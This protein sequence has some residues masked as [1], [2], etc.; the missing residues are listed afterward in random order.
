MSR[1]M[2]RA[3]FALCGLMLLASGPAAA[4]KLALV[5][6]NS[7]YAKVGTLANPVNDATAM[8]RALTGIG[9]KVTL[10]TDARKP[11]LEAALNGFGQVVTPADQVLVFYAGHGVQAAGRNYL[12]PVDARLEEERSLRLETVDLDVIMDQIER[13]A[14]RV[15]ILDA[16]R[17]NPFP[18]ASR[19]GS[20][21]LAA[22]TAPSGSL[23][24]YSTA[25]GQTASDGS[26]ANGLYTAALLKAVAKDVP[27]ESMFKEVRRTVAQASGGAQVPWE[28]SSLTG[29][30]VLAATAPVPA[31]A[32]GLPAPADGS[33][34]RVAAAV[35]P[36]PPAAAGTQPEA[37]GLE[38]HAMPAG[39]EP[40]PGP[41]G[42]P[43]RGAA[44]AGR[45]LDAVRAQANER[46]KARDFAGARRILEEARDSG[47]FPPPAAAFLELWIAKTFAGEGRRREALQ[48]LA[49][50]AQ[51]RPRAPA[52]V[53]A[54]L[55]SAH[56]FGML[57]QGADAC[58]ELA[59]FHRAFAAASRMPLEQRNPK[60]AERARKLAEHLHCPAGGG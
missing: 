16:C 28:S 49:E 8:A 3:G 25:P 36:S 34:Q 30:L 22:V 52:G 24:A 10:L 7:H 51:S 45:P 54:H 50:L 40:A 29:D 58:R 44:G 48:R 5:V 18:A 32:P 11:E 20:H 53:L 42:S 43:G 56:L 55:E 9:F 23:I 41:G 13:A 31:T 33:A 21:G 14:V 15:V 26:G 6:G 37:E 47:R 17:N 35:A 57:E 38:D 46:W 4:E 60:L 27:V 2:R 1:M 59:A 12:I 39:D 19:G